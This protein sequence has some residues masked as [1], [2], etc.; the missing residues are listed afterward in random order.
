M[1]P[2][3]QLADFVGRALE[4]GRSRD[5]IAQALQ[6]AGWQ[7]SEVARALAAWAEAPF[8]PPVPRP[9]AMVSAREAF[10][11]L[12]L[13]SALAF[14]VWHIVSLGFTLIDLW[15]GRPLPDDYMADYRR[16]GLRWSVAMLVVTV[17]V[18]LWMNAR[19]ARAMHDD[20]ARARSALRK[21]FGHLTLFLALFTLAG[22]AVW[23]IY[24]L[25]SGDLTG[26]VALKA[27]FLM[28]VAGLVGLYYRRETGAADAA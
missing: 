12:V 23:V 8:T 13:F 17:P 27:L 11:Y 15:L 10:G 14:A 16:A 20:P 6:G 25:L 1:K 7:G 3:D 18:F 4:Q 21:W 2:A 24:S 5:D 28:V 19:L 26:Q 22:D 9:R